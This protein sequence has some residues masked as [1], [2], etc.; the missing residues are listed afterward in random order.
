ME[1]VTKVLK[2]K[3]LGYALPFFVLVIGGSFFVAEF[4]KIRYEHEMRL[5][6]VVVSL[7]PI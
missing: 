6:D 1:R 7:L 2:S 5:T 4:S 3:T